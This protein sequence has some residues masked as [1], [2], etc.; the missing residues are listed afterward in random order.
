MPDTHGRPTGVAQLIVTFAIVFV[1]ACA[2]A[3]SIAWP[4]DAYFL[5]GAPLWWM[6]WLALSPFAWMLQRCTSGRQA[7]ALGWWFATVW[8]SA[9]FWWL[10]VAMHT[11][12]GLHGLLAVVAVV[13][14]AGALGVYYAVVCG[15]YWRL[16]RTG[17]LVASLAFA[18]L[19]TLAEMARGIWL[20]GFGWGAIGYAHIDGPLAWYVPWVG[21]Y[22]V[23]A[24]AAW[25]AM[26]LALLRRGRWRHVLAVA[27][28]WFAP[29][30]LPSSLNDWSAPAGS[31]SV[32]LLQGNIPQDEKFEA[33]SGVPLALQWYDEQLQ[34]NRSEMVVAPETA[35][36][37]LPQQLPLGYWE[38]LQSRFF[39]SRQ[40]ALIGIP[41]GNYA[42]GY[43]NS[44]LGLR[45][46]LAES[47]RYDKHH[48]VPFGEFIPPLF[49]WFTALMN[50]PLG[51]FNR[52][53]LGQASFTVAGQRVAPNICYEDL[54]GEEL[55]TR[56]VDAASAPTLFANVSNIGWFGDTVAIDQH[57]HISRM[58]ALE[59][60]RP[61]VRA[62]NTGATVILDHKA[63]VSASLPRH[64][65]GVLEGRVEGR[66]GMTPFAWWV[67][68]LGLWPLWLWVLLVWAWAARQPQQD[69]GPP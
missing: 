68:R 33:G 12:A 63:Q 62:T 31:L 2:Q 36:P 32:T 38:A 44:V 7:A 14:L 29:L 30:A 42:E 60:Q 22:G 26:S 37:L 1:A 57:L 21:A 59:F 10:Y 34:A 55:A 56:F 43:T 54:F 24:L 39:H 6:Q 48:L 35:V 25:S 11:Y 8:L 61:F 41:L 66:T 16:R 67:S 51:D 69:A 3:A 13:A 15:L 40:A 23:G 52:G 18:A 4:F 45:G 5:K 27:L 47:W 19:W 49:K 46:E 53:A 9:T 50:I 58:R 20:T 28:V 65:R 17:P 64:T